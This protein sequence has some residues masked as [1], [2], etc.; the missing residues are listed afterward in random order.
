VLAESAG[1]TERQKTHGHWL[2]PV[3]TLSLSSALRWE[4]TT[5]PY[6]LLTVRAPG[7]RR[8]PQR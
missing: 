7:W 8:A 1:T 2:L 4:Q 6:H 5:M 3:R